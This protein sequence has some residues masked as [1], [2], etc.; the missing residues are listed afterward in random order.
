MDRG[1]EREQVLQPDQRFGPQGTAQLGV[2]EVLQVENAAAMHPLLGQ[3]Q[4][5]PGLA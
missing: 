1:V 3:L 2:A 5:R 4:G